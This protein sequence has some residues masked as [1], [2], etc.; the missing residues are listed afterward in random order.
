MKKTRINTDLH[1]SFKIYDHR[2]HRETQRFVLCFNKF[3]VF[4]K[5]KFK[6]KTVGTKT[7]F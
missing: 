4:G 5:L 6:G 1:C 2:V 3:A 7:Y